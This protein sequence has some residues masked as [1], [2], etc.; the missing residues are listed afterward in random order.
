MCQN[1]RRKYITSYNMFC[2]FNMKHI[3][4]IMLMFLS[5]TW[6]ILMY[7]VNIF[8]FSKGNNLY[9]IKYLGVDTFS[10][11]SLIWN[12]RQKLTVFKR[13]DTTPELTGKLP[14]L[15][16]YKCPCWYEAAPESGR[17]LRCL[18]YFYVIGVPKCG[19]TDLCNRIMMHPLISDKVMKGNHWFTEY[20]Y[21]RFAALSNYLQ[22]FDYAVETDIKGIQT[23]NGYHNAIFGDCTPSLSW[24]SRRL[25]VRARKG[26]QTGEPPSN[27]DIIKHLNPHSKS[28]A[29]LRNPTERLYS[30]YLFF[31]EEGTSNPEEFHER[32]LNS[33]R[34]MTMCLQ[35]NTLRYCVYYE[36]KG[37]ASYRMAE[38]VRLQVGIYHVF[39]EDFL[40]AFGREQMLVI[41][42]E[43]YSN[44]IN[45]T[46]QKVFS[47]LGVGSV[48]DPVLFKNITSIGR[49]NVRSGGDTL[50]GDML[51]ETRQL[52]SDFYKPYNERLKALLG[53]EFDYNQN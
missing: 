38:K 42:L 15:S 21:G 17:K 23:Q 41:K 32:V 25:F 7:I 36:K 53:K 50:V 31:N 20:R 26:N 24:N 29:I 28:I 34:N 35:N 48:R 4:N 2:M 46:M 52:L 6:L 1:I 9:L 40:K 43:N 19:T 27:A 33:I 14:F 47:F 49:A 39:L 8:L 44:K 11:A 16:N 22:L 37:R 10:D 45:E 13:I 3:R 18:P 30:E 51:P 12:E 5:A